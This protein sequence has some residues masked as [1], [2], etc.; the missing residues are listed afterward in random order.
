MT[1]GKNTKKRK[2]KPK[3]CRWCKE[4]FEPRNSLQVV[5]SPKCSIEKVRHENRLKEQRKRDEVLKVERAE[6]RQRKLKVKPRSYWANRA[7]KAVNRYIRERD[8]DKNCISCGAIESVQWDA[9]HYRTVASSPQLRFHEDNIHKQCVVCNQ[10]KSGNIAPYRLALI[11]KIGLE[12]LEF[13]ENNNESKR[14]TVEELQAIE[15]EYKNKL[16]ELSNK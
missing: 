1:H 6:I 3:A 11:E 4:T 5:C 12:R 13:I 14:W 7:Q 15:V 2:L 16:K 9:G 8:A 10:Y